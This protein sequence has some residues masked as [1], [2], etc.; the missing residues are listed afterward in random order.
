MMPLRSTWKWVTGKPFTSRG[1][2][3]SHDRIAMM[4]N[5]RTLSERGA[6]AAPASLAVPARA[7]TVAVLLPSL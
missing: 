7:V 5:C 2:M 3:A 4:P 1:Y 6:P